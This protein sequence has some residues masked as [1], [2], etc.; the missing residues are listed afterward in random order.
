MIK[1]RAAFLIAFC[2]TLAIGHPAAANKEELVRRLK[3]C[4]IITSIITRSQCYDL[5]IDDYNPD[6]LERNP[7]AP[8]TAGKW[9]QTLEKSQIDDSQ[10]A[11]LTLVSDDYIQTSE[12]YLRPSLV[13]RCS[14]GKTEGYIIWD[15]PVFIKNAAT[16]H[17]N[18]V[19]VNIRIGDQQTVAE[20]WKPSGDNQATFIQNVPQL[21]PKLLNQPNLF[22]KIWPPNR[23]P[24]TANFDIR[25]LA[26]VVTP[27]RQACKW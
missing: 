7:T 25:G 1:T 16:P 13:L 8:N 20:K 17:V 22:V 14:E 3:E 2:C 5:A 21:V 26:N 19:T 11:Y 9:K 6:T 10:N 12:K 18:D 27:L 15:M 4:K 23:D 24:I